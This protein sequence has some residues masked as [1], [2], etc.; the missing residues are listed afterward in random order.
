MSHS[1]L[2]WQ[3]F[4][5]PED[6]TLKLMEFADRNSLTASASTSKGNSKPGSNC[7]ST[8]GSRPSTS[9]D[10]IAALG[11]AQEEGGGTSSSAASTGVMAGVERIQQ[12]QRDRSG[13]NLSDVGLPLDRAS[14]G[15][16]GGGGGSKVGGLGIADGGIAGSVAARTLDHSSK[17]RS[18]SEASS[19]LELSEAATESTA[20]PA[21]ALNSRPLPDYGPVPDDPTTAT[22][23][24]AGTGTTGTI[25]VKV[26]IK[27]PSGKSYAR[28][29]P[30]NT[31]VRALFAVVVQ[32]EAAELSSSSPS[33]SSRTPT[34]PAEFDLVTRFPVQSLRTKLDSTLEECNLVGSQVMFRWVDNP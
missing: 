10:D 17:E 29:Y 24:E 18:G 1:P 30:P 6:L 7:N 28:A 2:I 26:S 15:S 33:P 9:Y 4:I 20:A 5:T 3:G 25:I 34:A 11:A 12:Q 13:S 16:S 31:P 32:Q 22:G 27:L 14:F 8:P 23:A 19:S 21:A